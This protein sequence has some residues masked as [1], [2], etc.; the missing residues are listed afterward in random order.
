[1]RAWSSWKAGSTR[2]CRLPAGLSRISFLRLDGD[3][4]ASTRDAIVAL[5]PLLAPGG[6]IYVDDY[7]AYGGCRLAIDEYRAQHAITTPMVKIWQ[8]FT[9]FARGRATPQ[10]KRGYGFEAVWWIKE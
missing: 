8:N 5:Y 4:Y 1:M 3:L 6:A 7:G 10:T 2:R 9:P